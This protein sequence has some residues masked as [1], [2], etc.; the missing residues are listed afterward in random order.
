MFPGTI[1][2]I[3]DRVSSDN[4]AWQN[5]PLDPVYLIV[6]MDGIVFKVRK[7]KSCQTI[8]LPLDS[9]EGEK[10]CSVWLQARKH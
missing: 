2:R 1:S 4:I 7:L 8:Y 9:I 3:T 6:W 5:R 10:K